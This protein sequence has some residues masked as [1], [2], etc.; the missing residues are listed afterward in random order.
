MYLHECPM[1]TYVQ[2]YAIRN[3]EVWMDSVQRGCRAVS[4]CCL[5]P[6]AVF[7][8]WNSS[9]LFVKVI[10]HHVAM[11]LKMRMFLF[12]ASHDLLLHKCMQFFKQTK[13][14]HHPCSHDGFESW[15]PP[16]KKIKNWLVCFEK[17]SYV[18]IAGQMKLSV[19]KWHVPFTTTSTCH[20]FFKLCFNILAINVCIPVKRV[21]KAHLSHCNLFFPFQFEKNTNIWTFLGLIISPVWYKTLS[22]KMYGFIQIPTLIQN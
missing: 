8:F 22:N 16:Q 20:I 9:L 21:V 4:Q 19:F 3:D 11:H 1:C 14:P 6:G 17:P 2:A 13:R 10:K 7:I 12:P 18:K 5:V 15:P